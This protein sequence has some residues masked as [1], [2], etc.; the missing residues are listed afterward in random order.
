MTPTSA[1]AS[2]GLR[3]HR[4][5]S[6]TSEVALADDIRVTFDINQYDTFTVTDADLNLLTGL[7]TFS[8]ALTGPTGTLC[9]TETVAFVPPAEP[10]VTN[11]PRLD[12]LVTLTACVLAVSYYK[13]AVPP[14]FQVALPGMTLAAVDYL[15]VVLRDG[16]AEFAY[17]NGLPE[18]LTPQI[19]LTRSTR[20]AAS[21]P[22]LFTPTGP[23]L[24]L[25]GGGKDSIVSVEALKVAGITLTQLVINPKEPHRQV[26]AV[27]GVPALFLT[28]T[29][30]PALAQ[31]T[32]DG[33]LNGHVPVTA[34]NTL[35][36]LI[37]AELCP[38]PG[39]VILS[40]EAS[41]SEV[42]LTW[43]TQSGKQIPVNHQWSKSWVAEQHLNTVLAAHVGLQHAHFSLLRPYSELQIGAAY[44]RRAGDYDQVVVSCNTAFTVSATPANKWCGRCDKC[45]FVALVLAPA[46]SPTRLQSIIGHDPLNDPAQVPDYAALLGLT[47]AKPFDCVGTI[48]EAQQALHALTEDPRWRDHL[49]VARYISDLP[50]SPSSSTIPARTSAP[51]LYREAADA[52]LS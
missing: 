4:I 45:R 30:D 52:Y 25:V 19:I 51:K 43:T 40:N 22:E 21:T 2:G 37:Q 42:T 36:A 15:Q 7:A 16:L 1:Q 18:P 50:V 28:R 34:V 27:A 29:L 9:F 13:T 12:A 20:A 26:C 33:A 11:Q 5:M 44:A 10:G 41:A 17:R 23:P 46:M 49:V 38:R 14:V 48:S 24:V 6:T 3:P 31:L 47:S 8:Y 35:L 32:A 39:P